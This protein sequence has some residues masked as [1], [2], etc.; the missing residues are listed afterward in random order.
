MTDRWTV[1]A[2]VVSLALIT[3][4]S[5]AAAT[6]LLAFDKAAP[7][8]LWAL[9]GAGAGAL[10]TLLA[11]TSVEPLGGTSTS[12]TT[13]STTTSDEDLPPESFGRETP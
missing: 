7:D 8:G 6:A 9:A 3:V 1:R 13:T 11:R 12:T 4:V 2:V 5:I 10:G